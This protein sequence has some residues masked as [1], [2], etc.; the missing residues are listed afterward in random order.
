MLDSVKKDPQA[1]LDPATAESL[2]EILAEAGSGD[3]PVADSLL[4]SLNAALAGAL[5]NV[6]TVLTAAA[7]LSFAMALFLRVR[8][9]AETRSAGRRLDA[10]C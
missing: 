3:S 8:T 5:S 2:K 10:P 7:A 9:D 6:F 1:L 4:D